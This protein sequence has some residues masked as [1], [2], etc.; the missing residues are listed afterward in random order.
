[1]MRALLPSACLLLLTALSACV[2]TSDP[3]KPVDENPNR[4]MYHTADFTYAIHFASAADALSPEET[5]GLQAFLQHSSAR[6][7]DK[8]TV[9]GEASPIGQTRSARVREMLKHAGLAAVPGVDVN[10]AP[11]TVTIVLTEQ[12]VTEPPKCGDWP[13][14]AGDAPSNAPSL[15]LGC[16]LRNNL[17][18]QVV[19]KRDLAVGRTPGPADAEPSIRAVQKYR[20]GKLD[21]DKDDSPS[22]NNAAANSA[23][24]AADAA[25]SMAN[26]P[27]GGSNNGQ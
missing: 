9:S 25:A 8:V 12:V 10:L 26:P 27:G 20:E 16:A 7:E 23:T 22:Q 15:Y 18:Q 17:Y 21:K 4:F 14:F 2:G 6:P 11:N 3:S 19:D 13:L 24:G 5:Q 1:M